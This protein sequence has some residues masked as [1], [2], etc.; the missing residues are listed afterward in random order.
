MKSILSIVVLLITTNLCFS[1]IKLKGIIKSNE[2]TPLP[3]V[4]IGI[5][6]KEVG[7]VSDVDG[8]FSLTIPSSGKKD[9]IKISSI[10]YESKQFLVEDFI[11][12]L[13]KNNE[14]TLLENIETLE[15]VVISNRRKRQRNFGNRGKSRKSLIE[16]SSDALGNEI[17]IRVK[18]KRSPTLIK[19]FNATVLSRKYKSFKFRLNIYN[20]KD[21]L[22]YE[23]LL[24]QNII[25]SEQ[26]IKEGKLSIDLEEYDIYVEEDF[27]IGVEWI[28]NKDEKKLKFSAGI[29]GNRT[30]VRRTSQSKWFKLDVGSVGF[31]VDVEY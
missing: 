12:I 18:I 27:V 20:L 14:V 30:Y 10:A 6:N 3:Y 9:S 2:G 24:T 15:E 7:T 28:E 17:G 4:N 8:N 25:I 23:N 26:H 16:F 5:V 29:F 13:E 1:Q 22:P 21:G 19:R 11:K 31:N